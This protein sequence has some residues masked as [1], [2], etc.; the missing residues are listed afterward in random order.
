MEDERKLMLSDLEA[1]MANK[2]NLE[3]FK[4]AVALN[5]YFFPGH[6]DD[7]SCTCTF[8]VLVKRLSTFWSE[9]GEQE[10]NN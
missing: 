1:L 8:G 4:Q 5:N 10:L 3:F 2:R 6:I 7:G 9:T